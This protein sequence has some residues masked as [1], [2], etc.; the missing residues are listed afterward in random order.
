MIRARGA[1]EREGHDEGEV[2]T[3]KWRVISSDRGLRAL[4]SLRSRDPPRRCDFVGFQC[5]DL[6]GKHR[7]ESDPSPR[8]GDELHR[9]AGMLAVD[10][11][12]HT[13]IAGLQ[14]VFGKVLGQRNTFVFF[15]YRG[16]TSA[17]VRL[18]SPTLHGLPQL[19]CG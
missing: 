17:G 8:H 15:E 7:Y 5:A 6:L 14:P 10:M 3:V 2:R 1:W 19:C 11:Y 12:D 18:P 13:D 16:V 4:I 9:T